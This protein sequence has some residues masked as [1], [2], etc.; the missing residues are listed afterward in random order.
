MSRRPLLT[1]LLLSHLVACGGAPSKASSPSGLSETGGEGA[2]DS[3]AGGEEVGGL[4]LA[5]DPLSL[6]PMVSE[7]ALR[8][9]IET[10]EGFGT[11]YTG[12]PGN[13]E[14]AVFLAD[15]LRALG[16][17]VEEAPFMGAGGGA[18]INIIAR[19]AGLERPDELFLYSAHYDSTSEQAETLAPGA[20]DN[21]SAVA[22]GLE[23]GRLLG[24]LPTASSWWIVF[25]GAEEQGSLGSAVLVEQMADEGLVAE[26]VIAPDMIG[27][28][29]LGEADAFDILG[30]EDSEHLVEEMAGVA[31]TLGVSHKDWVN[32]RHCY[33][34]DHSNYQEAGMPSLAPMDCVEAH[35]ISTSDEELAHYHQSTDRLDTLDLGFT[36]KV[37]GVLV[38]TF[39]GWVEPH[40]PAEGSGALGSAAEGA[41]RP[42]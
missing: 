12:T 17:E 8:A 36:T 24:P 11:R 39:A 38:A 34:D 26:A 37:A 29:P 3:G 6:A 1:A 5:V 13:A 20:D 30:D 35:N 22:V 4:G 21:A 32:H 15:R 40:E 31:D 25:T 7:E 10:L 19:R 41:R 33:G 16:F 18:A 9:D 27:Y 28:W 14:A 42:R 2:A 23:L